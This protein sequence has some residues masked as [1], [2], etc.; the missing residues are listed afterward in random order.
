MENYDDYC[1]IF[2]LV[3]EKVMVNLQMHNLQGIKYFKKLD[4]AD[5]K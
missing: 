5:L 1:D 2:S 4:S 3:Y